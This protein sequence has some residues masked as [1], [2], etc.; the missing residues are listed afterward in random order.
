MA[1]SRPLTEEQRDQLYD[2]LLSHTYPDVQM[3]AAKPLG[4]GLARGHNA[5][6]L[7]FYTVT[8]KPFRLSVA[9]EPVKVPAS[10]SS[11]S[12]RYNQGCAGNQEVSNL[13]TQLIIEK[14]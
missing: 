10:A 11:R 2:W 14:C 5:T 7:N 12:S 13:H 1:K 4:D 3:L 8:T 6:F 9:V